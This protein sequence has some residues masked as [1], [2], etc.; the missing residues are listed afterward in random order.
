MELENVEFF[1]SDPFDKGNHRT[2]GDMCDPV[3]EANAHNQ[4]ISKICQFWD[5]SADSSTANMFMIGLS[6]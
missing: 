3:C 2:E 5:F 6:M 4:A 1:R